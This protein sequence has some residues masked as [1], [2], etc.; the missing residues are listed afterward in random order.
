MVV[1][2]DDDLESVPLEELT[3]GQ[4]HDY[5]NWAGPIKVPA[6]TMMAY[7]LAELAG[8]MPDGGDSIR[9]DRYANRIYFL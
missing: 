8:S 7:K 9:A 6:V 5:P 3:W 1:Q 2:R 4:C